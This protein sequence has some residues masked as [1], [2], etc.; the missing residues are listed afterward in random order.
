MQRKLR[1]CYDV[2]LVAMVV[3]DADA[4]LEGLDTEKTDKTERGHAVPQGSIDGAVF[5]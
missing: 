5:V 4:K 3:F 2:A 1:G